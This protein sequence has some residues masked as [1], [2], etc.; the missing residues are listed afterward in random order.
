MDLMRHMLVVSQDSN[1]VKYT[2]MLV[3]RGLSSAKQ[4]EPLLTVMEQSVSHD[5]VEM[6]RE[7][8]WCSPSNGGQ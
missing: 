1:S 8:R 3:R 7:K 2:G 5:V 6:H 4:T